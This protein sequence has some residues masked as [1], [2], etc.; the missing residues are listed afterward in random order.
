MLAHPPL[1]PRAQNEAADASS[2]AGSPFSHREKVQFGAIRSGSGAPITSAIAH[3]V[4]RNSA[5]LW[6]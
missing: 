2:C 4:A 5:S 1:I 3:W 6:W